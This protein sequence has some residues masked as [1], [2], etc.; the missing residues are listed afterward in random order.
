MGASSKEAEVVANQ[1][2][3]ANLRGQDGHG[4]LMLPLYAKSVREG[5]MKF[6]VEA[7]VVREA[8]SSALVD[9]NWGFGQVVGSRAMDIAIEKAKMH[10]ISCV[11]VFNCGHLGM[12]AHYPMMAIEQDMIGITLCNS[13]AEVAP[14][15]GRARKLGT[16]PV[17]IGIPANEEKP[18]VLDMATSVVAA[19]K[20]RAKHARGEKLPEGWVIDSMGRPTVD[21]AVFMGGEGML[22]PMAGYKGFGLSLIVDVLGGVLTGAGCASMDHPGGNGTI[23]SVINVDSFIPV[24]E[25][26]KKVDSLI[27]SIKSCP[28]APGFDEI[29][30]PG[31]LEFRES[32]KRYRE[33]IL[34]DDTTWQSIALL[35]K[36]LGVEME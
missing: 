3:E 15:G 14:Y 9:G 13:I 1:L 4:V 30:M 21:P 28:T 36:E 29:I 24:W 25:F 16:N 6:G 5:R 34:V 33:G 7:R 17:S 32:E 18:I 11:G 26:K 35:A 23:M 27:R 2:V 8:P 10:S 20:V 31:E 12:L 19:G 22:L